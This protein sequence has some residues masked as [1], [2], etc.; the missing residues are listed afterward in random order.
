VVTGGSRF[1]GLQD[2]DNVEA[3]LTLMFR[4][5]LIDQRYVRVLC[6]LLVADWHQRHEDV[7]LALQELSDP[8]AVPALL[9]A[10][11]MDLPYL[12]HDENRALSRKCIWALSDIRTQDAIAALALLAES[13]KDVVWELAVGHM[14]KIINGGPPS[15]RS[16]RPRLSG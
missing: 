12:E 6:D 5:D 7:A 14:I 9:R 2:A 1:A 3:A 15:Q 8:A 11:V 13:K 4:F 10:A 16:Q